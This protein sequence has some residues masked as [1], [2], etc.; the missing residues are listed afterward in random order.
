MSLLGFASSSTRTMPST[1]TAATAVP[2]RMKKRAS[3]ARA[4]AAFW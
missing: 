1:S 4:T 2:K 3:D